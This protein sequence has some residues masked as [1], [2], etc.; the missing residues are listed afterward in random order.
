MRIIATWSCLTNLGRVFD[1]SPV[2]LSTK[3]MSAYKRTMETFINYMSLESEE[4][5]KTYL[6]RYFFG[7]AVYVHDSWVARTDNWF[8]F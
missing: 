7:G 4:Q 8:V 6:H 5:L 2:F 1:F 3:Q